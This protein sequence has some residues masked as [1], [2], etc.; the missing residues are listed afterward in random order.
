M[1]KGIARSQTAHAQTRLPV[2]PGIMR[3]LQ[4]VCISGQLSNY[5]SR[6]LW[7]VCCL[8]YFGFLRSGEFTMSD[9]S[10]APSICASDLEVDSHQN[11]SIV[12]VHLCRAKTNPFGAGVSI[13]VGRTGTPLCPVSALLN[14]MTVCPQG[15]GPL[16]VHE[17]SSPLTRSWFV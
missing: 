7:A 4:E 9:L 2:T 11:P 8:G 13:Y 10:T 14:F 5:Q 16:F 1:L 6:M 12:R 15:G 3:K 17:D